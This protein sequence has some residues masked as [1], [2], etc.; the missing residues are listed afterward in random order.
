MPASQLP[1]NFMGSNFTVINYVPCLLRRGVLDGLAPWL[2]GL[3]K[4]FPESLFNLARI[5]CFSWSCGFAGSTV[6]IIMQAKYY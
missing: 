2:P 4:D 1:Y 5:S 3:L 6:I